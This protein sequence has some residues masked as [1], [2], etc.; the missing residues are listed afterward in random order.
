MAIH[1]TMNVAGM[2]LNRGDGQTRDAHYLIKAM[3]PRRA[4]V[5]SHPASLKAFGSASA[6]VP[7]IKLNRKMKPDYRKS[8][9]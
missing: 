1:S 9:V 4:P 2:K 8:N 5:R 3:K 7:R 6:P